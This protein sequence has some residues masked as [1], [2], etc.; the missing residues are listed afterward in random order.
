MAGAKASGSRATAPSA[1]NTS[2][3]HRA[4]E[5]CLR[6]VSVL[7]ASS[8]AALVSSEVKHRFFDDKE[9]YFFSGLFC[10]ES[11]WHIINGFPAFCDYVFKSI[12]GFLFFFNPVVEKIFKA[13]QCHH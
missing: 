8:A 4:A 1:S 9:L 11:C 5:L 13:L 7:L 3:E 10:V 2:S 6:H 12:Q